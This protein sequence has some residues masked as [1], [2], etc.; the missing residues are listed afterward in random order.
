MIICQHNLQFNDLPI[1]S[2][3]WQYCPFTTIPIHNIWTSEDIHGKKCEHFGR[4]SNKVSSSRSPEVNR[5]TRLSLLIDIGISVLIVYISQ[6]KYQRDIEHRCA[7]SPRPPPSSPPKPLAHRS[8]FACP[9]VRALGCFQDQRPLSGSKYR[10]CTLFWP[11]WQV[12]WT[13]FKVLTFSQGCT[14]YYLVNAFQEII[15]RNF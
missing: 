12:F 15:C 8:S 13:K 2:L 9:E 3:P 11:I 4:F 7:R 5:P 1:L 10:L 14:P 6:P